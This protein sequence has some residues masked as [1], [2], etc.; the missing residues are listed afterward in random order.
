MNKRIIIFI[1]SIAIAAV[2]SWWI[3]QTDWSPASVN[4]AYATLA[5]FFL[6]VLVSSQQ[7]E[8]DIFSKAER[9][10]S[11]F[12]LSYIVFFHF[13]YAPIKQYFFEALITRASF[14][15][16]MLSLML[17]MIFF[18]LF[19][20]VFLII[21][22]FARVGLFPSWRIFNNEAMFFVL[23]ALFLPAVAIF[24]LFFQWK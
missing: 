17:F 21:S 2:S 16:D 13:C 9:V 7:Y 24:V 12:L 10:V 5:I 22:R 19:G 1:I 20:T 3:I 23:R 6:A 8:E 18:V 4:L 14:M 11:A 15:A